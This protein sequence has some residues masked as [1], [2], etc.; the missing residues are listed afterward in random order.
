MAALPSCLVACLRFGVLVASPCCHVASVDPAGSPFG[1][2]LPAWLH[3]SQRRPDQPPT[4]PN[5]GNA[6]RTTPTGE[7]P[8]HAGRRSGR[9][10]PGGGSR[11]RTTPPAVASASQTANPLAAPAAGGSSMSG[12]TADEMPVRMKSMQTTDRRRSRSEVSSQSRPRHAC[13]PGLHRLECSPV[14]FRT[15]I[16]T[17]V[18]TEPRAAGPWISCTTME[19]RSWNAKRFFRGGGRDHP[20]H[21]EAVQANSA[22]IFASPLLAECT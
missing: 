22:S 7:R 6:E 13:S 12:G 10:H 9:H 8:P 14:L 18:A 2:L 5:E 3:R 1:L 20:G 16:P 21:Q 17:S 4:E 15:R 11:P 19:G